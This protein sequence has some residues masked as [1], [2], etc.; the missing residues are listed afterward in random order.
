MCEGE[1]IDV[2][3]KTPRYLPD[4]VPLQVS[5]RVWFHRARW[6]YYAAHIVEGSQKWMN[7]TRV[8]FDIRFLRDATI[9]KK[10][11]VR[12]TRTRVAVD[13]LCPRYLADSHC[14]NGGFDRLGSTNLL[15]EDD[16]VI[17]PLLALIFNA[18]T[19]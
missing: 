11:D 17:K 6:G 12:H 7:G 4:G 5:K 8:A 10:G 19:E 14:L 13:R 18:V 3:P 2:V 15:S 9:S 1:L 16:F